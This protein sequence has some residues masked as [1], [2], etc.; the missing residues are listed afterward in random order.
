MTSP[1]LATAFRFRVSF[2][3]AEDADPSAPVIGTGGFAE[4]TGL[5]VEMEVSEYAEGGRNDAVVQ[6]V[7]RAKYSRLVL[8][9][10][11]LH[12]PGGP[13]N[14]ELWQWF[15]DTVSGIR[16]VRRYHVLVEVLDEQHSAV[17]GWEARRCVAAKL[18]G[19]QLNARTGEVAMEELHLAHEGLRIVGP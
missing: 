15:S 10:G 4:C 16:P 13:A 11:M 14:R 2:T 5:D 19:P 17:A 7:G 9:R 18:V 1:R 12:S 3:P 6:R 8:K